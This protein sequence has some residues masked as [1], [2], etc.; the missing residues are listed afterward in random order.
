MKRSILAVLLSLMA[1]AVLPFNGFAQTLHTPK[2][3]LEAGSLSGPVRSVDTTSAQG[4]EDTRTALPHTLEIYDTDGFLIDRY[5]INETGGVVSHTRYKRDHWNISMEIADGAR[6]EENYSMVTRTD[7]QN[8]V[9]LH[10]RH[11]ASGT[12]LDKLE[13]D[14]AT[15]VTTGAVTKNGEMTGQSATQRSETGAVSIHRSSD[16][17]FTE[18]TQN[19]D[20]YMTKYHMYDAS[21]KTDMVITNDNKGRNIETIQSSP[22]AYFKTVYTYA[23]NGFVATERTFGRDGSVTDNSRYE[24]QDDQYGNWIVQRRFSWTNGDKPPHWNHVATVRRVISYY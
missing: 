21:S 20:G 24:Y 16:G 7:P 10:E 23:E 4:A 5:R 8:A 6:P 19:A 15:R 11:D 18:T 2:N 17:S 9:T 22:G 12:M 14:P 1:A 3:M 13:T